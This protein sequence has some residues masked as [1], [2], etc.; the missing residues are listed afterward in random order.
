MV[1]SGLRATRFGY[2]SAISVVLV[3]VVLAVVIVPVAR[4]ARAAAGVLTVERTWISGAERRR[5]GTPSCW[6]PRR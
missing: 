5:S 2:A 4:I 6:R 1:D 3:A